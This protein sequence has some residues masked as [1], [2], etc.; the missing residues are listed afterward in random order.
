MESECSLLV[1]VTCKFPNG[2]SVGH[3][4]SKLLSTVLTKVVWTRS[5]ALREI[6]TLLCF[7]LLLCQLMPE[8][9]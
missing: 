2:G 5:S 7:S 4:M 8:L 6:H 3:S 9:F 1:D